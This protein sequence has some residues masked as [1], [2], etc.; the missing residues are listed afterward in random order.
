MS[1]SEKK[2]SS[3][4]FKCPKGQCTF[5]QWGDS[6]PFGKVQRWLEQG[7]N[8]EARG[9]EQTQTLRFGPTLS[10]LSSSDGSTCKPGTW[11]LDT[12]PTNTLHQSQPTLTQI[13]RDKNRCFKSF[14]FTI[15]QSLHPYD[16]VCLVIDMDGFRVDGRIGLLQLAWGFWTIGLQTFQTLQKP[17][18]QEEVWCELCKTTHSSSYGR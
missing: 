15:M 16:D 13:K 4:Y 8:P 3:L 10:E 11:I 1:K 14:Q 6:K 2:T 17:Y 5:S 12:S 9:I 7:V 18:R